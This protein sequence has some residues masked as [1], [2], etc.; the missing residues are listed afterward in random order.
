M[1][2]N[3]ISISINKRLTNKIKLNISNK[4]NFFT[5]KLLSKNINVCNI[6]YAVIIKDLGKVENIIKYKFVPNYSKVVKTVNLDY[7]KDIIIDIDQ[8]DPSTC[9][10]VKVNILEKNRAQS[11]V[12]ESNDLIVNTKMDLSDFFSGNNTI[13]K[14]KPDVLA[15]S[16]KDVLKISKANPD[17]TT[18]VDPKKIKSYILQA[19][20]FDNLSSFIDNGNRASKL[21]TNERKEKIL[22]A[23]E[24]SEFFEEKY[25]LNVDYKNVDAKKNPFMKN[26]WFMGPIYSYNDNY[27]KYI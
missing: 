19:R 26:E 25:L 3:Q 20:D 15:N 5:E 27:Q 16:E 17:L 24:I 11:V 23:N 8:L 2:N 12:S 13:S 6:F 9:Y 10:S 4:D 1:K 21:F 22:L 7:K 14:Y 18:F